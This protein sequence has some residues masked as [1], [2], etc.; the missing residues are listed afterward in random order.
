MSNRRYPEE[1]KIEAVKHFTER[2]LHADGNT[3]PCQGNMIWAPAD[4]SLGG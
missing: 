1:F 3:T 4:A 2:R